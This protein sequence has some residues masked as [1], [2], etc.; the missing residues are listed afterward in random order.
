MALVARGRLKAR[1]GDADAGAV[2]DE[3]LALAGPTG[4]LQRVG[5]VRAARAEAAWLAGDVERAADEAGSV[6]DLAQAKRHPWH[7][8]E[9][10]WWLAKAGRATG[11]TSGAALPWRLLLDGRWVE[12]AEAWAALECPYESARAL[13]ESDDVADVEQAHATFDRLGA[14]PAA[15]LAKRRLRE[16]G[17]PQIPRG[18]RAATRANPAGLTVRELEV[19]RLVA[20]GLPNG[21]IA[22]RL[23][24]SQRTVDHHV[25]AV[26]A[27]LEV[28][29]RREVGPAATEAGVDLG[30][31]A[32]PQNGQS[33]RPN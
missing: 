19:L 25:S 21:E 8:G 4:T 2:L 28:S 22:A 29:S 17:A 12:A 1:R 9:L 7:I 16:L 26:L 31:T 18:R 27:K 14:A 13:L 3:A 32:F 23:F 20:A 6:I 30:S 5:P 24:L 10:S 15:A 33:R 11:D